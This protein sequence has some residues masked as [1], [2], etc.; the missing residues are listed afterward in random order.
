MW[1]GFKL[2]SFSNQNMKQK[3]KLQHRFRFSISEV[4]LLSHLRWGRLQDDM[5]SAQPQSI[6]GGAY[7]AAVAIMCLNAWQLST[8]PA[9]PKLLQI[10]KFGSSKCGDLGG[11]KIQQLG[12]F[13]GTI[14]WYTI[15]CFLQRYADVSKEIT[16]SII[17][18]ENK[19][20]KQQETSCSDYTSTLK[21]EAICS[22]ETS[23]NCWQTA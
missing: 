16:A 12:T 3:W 13:K 10:S 21:M 20:S 1:R 23:V 5:R 22:S 15:P 9:A 18:I 6:S 19:L 14:F 7:I 2:M 17:R 8:C 11:Y 4:S